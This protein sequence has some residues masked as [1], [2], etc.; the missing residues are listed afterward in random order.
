MKKPYYNMQDR[1]EIRE[2]DTLS[3]AILKLKFAILIFLREIL[4]PVT[5]LVSKK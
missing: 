4:K 2:F 5:M 1:F 3:T